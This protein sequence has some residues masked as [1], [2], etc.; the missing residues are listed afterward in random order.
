MK[1]KFKRLDKQVMV[2]VKAHIGDG[3]VDLQSRV[4]FSLVPGERAAIP[5]GLAVAIPVGY[6]GFVIPRSG[7]AL[8]SG[9]SVVN[10]PG[11]IDS[12]YRGEIQVILINLGQE[13]VAFEAGDRI[14]QLAIAPV[15]EV[16]W[17]EV[18]D[19]DETERGEGGFGSTGV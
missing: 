11:L 4:A 2:P 17:E 6:A 9:L 8:R 1:V 3:A 13:T 15:P 12:G 14:G 16:E 5:T 18:E 7:H 10:G 19:L